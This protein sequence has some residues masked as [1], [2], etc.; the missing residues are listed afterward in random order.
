MF[1]YIYHPLCIDIYIFPPNRGICEKS[2]FPFL[3]IFAVNCKQQQPLWVSFL[4]EFHNHFRPHTAPFLSPSLIS[5]LQYSWRAS[6]FP[7]FS[8]S[9]GGIPDRRLRPLLVW[10]AHFSSVPLNHCDCAPLWSPHNYL[11]LSPVCNHQ[12]RDFECGTRL[13]HCVNKCIVAQYLWHTTRYHSLCLL[14]QCPPPYLPH[15]ILSI[16]LASSYLCCNKRL[17]RHR[18]VLRDSAPVDNPELKY[19]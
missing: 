12:R 6:F 18:F 10:P 4:S 1:A 9:R 7:S 2:V 11:W 13:R 15:S 17:K 3:R 16:F 19:R 8:V 5:S 14:R